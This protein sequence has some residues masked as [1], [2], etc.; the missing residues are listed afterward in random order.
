M[1]LK[2][3]QARHGVTDAAMRELMS[4][5]CP[6]VP[7]TTNST[8][9]ANTQSLIRLEAPK[10][11][12]TLLRNNS[13]ACKDDTGRLI[14]FGLGNDSERVNAAFKSS[15]LIGV[16]PVRGVGVFTAVEVKKPGWTKPTNDRERAQAAF[17]LHVQ[18]RG[19]IGIFATCPEDYVRAVEEARR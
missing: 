14:R 2:D 11:G 15:D 10:L 19:G 16:T 9:E 7:T 13:G 17:L 3:W 12:A 6:S 18:Q 8:S 1:T 4:L 5:V